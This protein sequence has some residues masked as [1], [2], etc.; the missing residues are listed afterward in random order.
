MSTADGCNEKDLPGSPVKKKSV[1]KTWPSDIAHHPDVA[2]L[3]TELRW[4][5][6]C[7][8]CNVQVRMRNQFRG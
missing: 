6:Y 5:V 4:W 2:N 1:D 8:I 3:D 7:K